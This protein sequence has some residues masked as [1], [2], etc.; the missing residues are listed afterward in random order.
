MKQIGIY[1]VYDEPIARG[2]M[3]QIYRGVDPQGHQV[4]VKEILPEFASDGS[5]VSRI[6]KE[7]KFLLRM[8]HPSIVKLYSA[9]RDPVTDC[10]YIVMEYVEGM[11]LE[12][13][14]LQNGP[15]PP[16]EA[17]AMVNSVLDALQHVHNALIIHRDIKPSN[18]MVRPDKSICLLDFGVS[19]S[20]APGEESLTALGTVIGTTGYMSPEQATG[21]SIDYR[22]DF[23]SL[24]CVMFFMLTGHHALPQTDNEVDMADAIKQNDIPPLSTYVPNLPPILQ[25]IVSKATR[26]DIRERY[27]TCYEFKRD[28]DNGTK[29]R[30]GGNRPQSVSVSIGRDQCDIVVTDS[31]CRISRHHADVELIV[32]TGN[33]SYVFKDCSS[34]GTYINGQIVKGKEVYISSHQPDPE[35]YLACVQ[36]GYLD[37]GLVKAELKKR[38]QALENL[39]QGLKDQGQ[40]QEDDPIQE[41]K[42]E[43][44]VHVNP[45]KTSFVSKEKNQFS[46]APTRKKS[47][48]LRYALL[49]LGATACVALGVSI[50]WFVMRTYVL[51]PPA[52]APVPVVSET[53]TTMVLPAAPAAETAETADPYPAGSSAVERGKKRSQNKKNA[54][55]SKAADKSRESKNDTKGKAAVTSHE[56]KNTMNVPKAKQPKMHKEPHGMEREHVMKENHSGEKM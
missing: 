45:E 47:R 50:S 32:N 36:E 53:D 48:S 46:S 44:P 28:L 37:W 38:S 23:Y 21:F 13:Y 6:E 20:L 14:V 33:T 52:P 2:G 39:S 5:I 4:V 34:N 49:G 15:L 16:E 24:G 54:T 9:F 35:I 1:E 7:V 26:L 51:Q 56:S 43:E 29:E 27:Q 18:I 8:D 19:K 12:T 42:P 22:S 40:P 10:Y 25:R 30:T 3:G 41:K 17:V 55:K 11:N 31:N